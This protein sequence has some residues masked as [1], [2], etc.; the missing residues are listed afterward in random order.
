MLTELCTITKI[1][2]LIGTSV[3]FGFSKLVQDDGQN[4]NFTPDRELNILIYGMPSYV[5]IYRSYKLIEMVQVFLV[6]PVS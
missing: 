3:H 2:K 5:T 6:H 1:T 4:I